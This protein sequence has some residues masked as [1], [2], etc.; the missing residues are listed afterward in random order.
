MGT[1]QEHKQ[2][3]DTVDQLIRQIVWHA[4]KQALHT[5]SRP[6]IDMT[7]PQMVTLFAIHA[8]QSC[9]MSELAD[10]TQQ[11]AGTLTGIVDRLIEDGLVE[12]VRDQDDRRVVHVA[13]TPEGNTRLA[14]VEAARRE[15]MARMLSHFN[16]IQLDQ[17]AGLLRLFLGGIH[18]LMHSP[19]MDQQREHNC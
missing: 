9:R 18:D 16:D 13:L 15:D 10:T 17:M 4:Q 12:R 14:K 8:A 5:L 1:E 11:S 7:L 19:A 6:E 2:R 3:I